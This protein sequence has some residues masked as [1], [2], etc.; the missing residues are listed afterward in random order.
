MRRKTLP[1][2][3]N[4][5]WQA[6]YQGNPIQRWWK[7][8]ISRAVQQFLPNSSS[9]LDIG[10]GSSPMLRHYPAAVGLDIDPDKLSYLRKELP[11]HKFLEGDAENLPFA[12]SSVDNI[13]CIEVLEHLNNPQKAI[14][15]ITRTLKTGGRAV[16]ATPETRGSRGLIWKIAG[17]FTPYTEQHEHALGLSWLKSACTSY[18]LTLENHKY[19]ALCDVVACFRKYN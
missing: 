3:P 14:S 13:T 18:G 11:A 10:C 12:N 2:D 7:Q 8:S 1:R 9:L 5:E 16:L 4:Y 17:M 6:Y 19:I 15:E